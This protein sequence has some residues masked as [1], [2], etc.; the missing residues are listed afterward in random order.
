M[1]VWES[2]ELLRWPGPGEASHKCFVKAP[3]LKTQRR[4]SEFAAQ[5]A[6]QYYNIMAVNAAMKYVDIQY[7]NDKIMAENNSDNVVGDGLEQS[8]RVSGKYKVQISSDGTYKVKSKNPELVKRGLDERLMRKLISISNDAGGD[9]NTYVRYTRASEPA[10][11]GEMIH[12]NA[13]PF[14]LGLPWYDWAYVY[15]EILGSDGTTN[16]QFYPSKILGFVEHDSEL[17]AIVLCS[18][19]SVPWS[20][21]EDN[22][23]V[24]FSVCEDEGEEQLIPLSALSHPLCIVPNYGADED[25]KKYLMILPKGQWSSYFG[26]FVQ[27]HID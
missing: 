27:N 25:E 21:V 20:E 14:L 19:E 1:L 23:V 7:T 9:S 15:Y 11:D 2:N 13:H 18:I 22:F 26:R 3:G 24:K 6:D 5:V 10:V 16:A 17:K 4:A 8:V 12:Y